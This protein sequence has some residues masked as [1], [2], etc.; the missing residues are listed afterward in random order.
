MLVG[1]AILVLIWLLSFT[2]IAGGSIAHM[3]LL[4]F[5]AGSIYK[6]L[7]IRSTAI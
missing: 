1:Y 7:T 4:L 3:F 6:L 2:Y 5:L